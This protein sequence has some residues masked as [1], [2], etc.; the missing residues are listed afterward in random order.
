MTRNREEIIIPS[1]QM[2]TQKEFMQK[3]KQRNSQRAAQPLAFVVTYGCQQNENDSERIRGMLAEAGYGFCEK[4]EDAD[5]ILYNTCAVRE[6]AE[7]KVYGNLGALK[8]LKRKK[9]ELIIG[10]C[11]CMMQ[12]EA[13]AKKIREK[14]THV[15]LVF[16]THTLYTLP[17]LLW[18]AL[19]THQRSFRLLDVDGYIAED[20]P[21][22]REGRVLAYVSIMYG[23]NNFCSYC[24]VPYVRGRERSRDAE[25]IV[26]EIRQ[27]AADGY[28]E[29]MLL[30]Q[31]VNS[32]GKDLAEEIDFSD[33]L[34]QVCE[35]EGIE[36]VRFMTSHPK[37]FHDK[38]MQ[39][40]AAQ[41]KICNQ[42]HLPVQAGS[43]AVLEAMNRRYTR[44]DYLEKVQKIR[45]LIPNIT[46]TTDII[47]GFPTET[48]KDFSQTLELLKEVR[49]DSIYSFIYSK[50]SGTPAAEMDM[51]LSDEAIHKN[52][53][54]LLELQ[55]GISREINDAYIGQT[56]EILVEGESKT[57]GA[58]VSGR[59]QGG[60]IVHMKGGPELVGK[61]V[62]VKI[63]A[64][65]TWFLTGEIL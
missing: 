42:L 61:L 46:L 33:L 10:V 7:L 34:V 62:T 28:K 5:L 27:V 60:K 55:N 52:F 24:I 25:D 53:D 6:H 2:Q 41:P 64:A 36:R 9:P 57:D 43:N 31:N 17:E 51:V 20:M 56:H 15:D 13:V 48:D 26:N 23:C 32:Y 1:A 38:L 39:T 54:Q 65:K 8:I 63:T 37:D 22:R 35:I 47:V 58:M 3:I 30:G 40:M 45:T 21:I 59:T 44:E 19:D 12:Q 18:R 4:A 49:F 11:G 16:G 14:Y 50:R 29:V